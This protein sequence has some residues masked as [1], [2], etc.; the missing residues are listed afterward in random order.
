MANPLFPTSGSVKVQEIFTDDY[1]LADEGGWYVSTNPT[2]GTGIAQTVCVD[3]A[4]TSSSTHAQFA[5]AF[6][7]YNNSSP[8]NPNALSIYL[9]Y[10]KLVVTVA[11]ASATNWKYSLRM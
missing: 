4:A 5:P 1:T 8:A 6:L 2:V 3:D 11:P 10:L 7:I 9:R